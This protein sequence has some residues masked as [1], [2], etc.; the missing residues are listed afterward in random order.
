MLLAPNKA[1]VLSACL[2]SLRTFFKF[3]IVEEKI[4]TASCWSLLTAIWSEHGIQLVPD[5]VYLVEDCKDS[6]VD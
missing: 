2:T 1:V 6:F 5:N 3:R 4:V